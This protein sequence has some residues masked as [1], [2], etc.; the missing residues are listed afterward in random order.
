M[1]LGKEQVVANHICDIQR[2]A[3][4]IDPLENGLRHPRILN[5][6]CNHRKAM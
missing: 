2:N 5:L 3:F 6:Y 4:G 1:G